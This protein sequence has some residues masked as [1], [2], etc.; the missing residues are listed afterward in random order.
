MGSNVGS[1][2]RGPKISEFIPNCK[3]EYDKQD[4]LVLEVDVPG[5]KKDCLKVEYEECGRLKISGERPEEKQFS[6]VFAVPGKCTAGEIRAVY[7][8][9]SQVLRIVMPGKTSAPLPV[10]VDNSMPNPKSESNLPGQSHGEAN[11]GNGTKIA[12]NVAAVAAVLA[13]IGVVTFFIICKS[14]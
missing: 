6:K 2:G 8:R 14:I 3:W 7:R 12:V 1:A 4:S 10:G 13:V 11:K 5:F 9:D